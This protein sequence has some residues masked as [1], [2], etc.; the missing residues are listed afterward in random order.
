MTDRTCPY[1]LAILTGRRVQC[2][3]PNCKRAY[4]NERNRRFQAEWKAQHGE[5]FGKRYDDKRA[6]RTWTCRWCGAERRTGPKRERVFCGSRCRAHHERR[7]ARRAA[8]HRRLDLASEGTVGNASWTM[9]WCQRCGSAFL[10][11]RSGV[12]YCTRGCKGSDRNDRRRAGAKGIK[13]TPGRRH[14]VFTRD[15]WV[16]HIC[17]RKV[18]RTACVPHPFAPTID[19]VIPL[20]ELAR[21]GSPDGPWNWRT[22]HFRC[23]STKREGVLP[24]GEQLAWC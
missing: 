4:R 17:H 11:S 9:G 13:V 19:H 15:R 10:S 16:C 24:G 3:S 20:A 18:R 5:R 6:T 7:E 22:A 23:N 2:G 14:V 12:R 21:T 8:A 1:C